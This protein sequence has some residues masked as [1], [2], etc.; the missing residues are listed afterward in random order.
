MLQEK[1]NDETSIFSCSILQTDEQPG[2]SS[3]NP[4]KAEDASVPSIP[5]VSYTAADPGTKVGEN[6]DESADTG[7]E[8]CPS[9]DAGVDVDEAYEEEKKPPDDEIDSE[10][11]NEDREDGMDSE[12][13]KEQGEEDSDVVQKGEVEGETKGEKT[14]IEGVHTETGENQIE[15]TEQIETVNLGPLTFYQND[16]KFGNTMEALKAQKEEGKFCDTVL[17]AGANEFKVCI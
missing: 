15:P 7:V 6:I 10:N 17:L 8:T 3:E 5:T 14:E 4:Q 13:I 2:A 1:G 16:Q 12:N 9:R 11:I